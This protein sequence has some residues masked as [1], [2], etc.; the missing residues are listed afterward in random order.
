M[1]TYTVTR[2][3]SAHATIVARNE[4][5]VMKLY[6][7]GVVDESLS[8][9]NHKDWTT[10]IKNEEGKVIHEHQELGQ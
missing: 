4:K 3:I 6:H 1:K 8:L 10:R 5:E 2:T 9:D 7:E